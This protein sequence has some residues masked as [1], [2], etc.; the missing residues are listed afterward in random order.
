MADDPEYPI[1]FSPLRVGPITLRN[2]IV[3]AAH[4]TGFADRGVFT[5]QLI[6]YHRE[7]ARGGAALI[8]SQAM[9]VTGDYLDL[10]N[11]DDG[12]IDAYR[13]VVA[14]V[15]EFGALYAAELYH[16]GSQGEYSGRGAERF[17][18]PSS[19]A[20]SYLDGR[21][22]V[23][24]ALDEAE[25]LAIV[26]AF[27]A[28]AARC[29]AARVPAIEL[30]FAHG[31][32]VEQFMSPRTNRRTD[33]W[34]G[35]LE[36]RVRFAEL[37]VR[38][39]REAAGPEIA[40]GARLTAAGLDKGDLDD[41]E[42]AE[43]IGT[44]GAWGRLDYVS[45]TMGHYS[46]ALNTARNV[47]NMTFAPG[48]WQRY[49]RLIKS[50][51]DVPVFMVGRI[52]HPHTAEDL[53]ATGSCDAVLMARALIADP[54]LPEKARTGRTADIR[55][56]VGAMNCLGRLEHGGGIRCIHNPRVGHELDFPEEVEQG[57]GGRRVV[58]IGA[59]PA[60]LESARVAAARGNQVTL[61]ERTDRVGGQVTLA[62]R[63]PGRAELAAIVD[64]LE[65][66][67]VASGV[68]IHTGHEVTADAIARLRP[69]VIV[70]A[71]GAAYRE[72]PAPGRAITADAIDALAGHVR[73]VS[74]HRALAGSVDARAI[75]VYDPASDWPGSMWRG[76]SPRAVPRCAT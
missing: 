14:A 30:H 63:T 52:N 49:G 70:V 64:W 33:D 65:Q 60:G 3:N 51:V 22:R 28:A 11:A 16:P 4:Q 72:R 40:V 23:P 38:G 56:C 27:T 1:L 66:Q 25:I 13:A 58:V 54:H 37:I 53:L 2:R 31:N 61:L 36:Q 55:P 43:I 42:M 45:L 20:A 24:H 5:E 50:V 71:T 57:E 62:A 41:Y 21:W 19:I 17:V 35:D 15:D 73:L 26:E 59:G 10:Y 6:E 48:L 18:A 32:L 47:P 76:C 12:V 68:Q 8:V 67:C 7:R 44:I 46:D 39:V 34:G 75:V 74:L 9:S 69:D 29:R